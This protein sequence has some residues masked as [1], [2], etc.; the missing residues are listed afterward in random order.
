MQRLLLE[1]TAR[2]RWEETGDPGL[3]GPDGAIVRPVAVATC[4]LD[5]AVLAG[6]Y[7]LA[8]PYPF[9]HEGVADVVEV[10]GNVATVAPGDRVVVPFQISCGACGPCARGRTGNCAAHP[11]MSTYGLGTMGG[12]EWGGLLA[13]LVSVPH[14]DAMLVRLPAGV[15]PVAVASASD[16]IP[17]AWRTVGPQLAAD[18]GAEVLVVGGDAGPNSIGLYAAGLAIAL[19]ASGVTYTDHHPGRLAIAAALGATVIDGLPP[20]KAGTFPITVDASGSPAGLRC[21]LN[22]TAPD[23]TCTSPS[24][25]LEDPSVPMLAMYSRCCTLHTGR[26]HARPA[27]PAVLDLVTGGFDPSAVTSAVVTRADA[28]EALARP[29][30]K[31]VITCT[32]SA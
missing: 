7:P 5:V 6:R 13:D 25:Y 30:M 27:I 8:G 22:S 18:P 20:R 31:L 12:L 9:G 2:V 24:V 19:G 15:D 21:A 1:G 11:R 3:A 14:A 29:P 10:G 32:A 16:N 4:D 26:A 17:D 28:A 23:G